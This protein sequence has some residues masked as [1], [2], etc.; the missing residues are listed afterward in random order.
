MRLRA[1]RYLCYVCSGI[2]NVFENSPFLAIKKRKQKYKSKHFHSKFKSPLKCSHCFIVAWLPTPHLK[3]DNLDYVA[4]SPI[5]F[6]KKIKHQV[7]LAYSRC[8]LKSVRMEQ[9]QY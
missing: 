3:E 9:A 4:E 5:L 1:P 2:V 6:K 7:K 8:I